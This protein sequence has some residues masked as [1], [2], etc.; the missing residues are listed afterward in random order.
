M[1]KKISLKDRQLLMEQEKLNLSGQLRQMNADARNMITSPARPEGT[2]FTLQSK[3]VNIK[4]LMEQLEEA[5]KEKSNKLQ[6]I[7]SNREQLAQLKS[8]LD[9]LN[10]RTKELQ[11][12][13][14]GGEID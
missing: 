12:E 1:E 3:Q 8:T 14:V 2:L 7:Q 6:G 9:E 13:I 11:V 4:Q 10:E 5:E